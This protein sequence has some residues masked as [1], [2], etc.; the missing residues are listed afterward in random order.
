M[1]K[2]GRVKGGKCVVVTAE[3]VEIGLLDAAKK[4]GKNH[5]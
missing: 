1:Y 4:Y 2:N 3:G 5:K